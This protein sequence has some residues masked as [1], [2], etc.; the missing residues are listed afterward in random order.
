MIEDRDSATGDEW[1]PWRGILRGLW[2]GGVAA[3]LLGVAVNLLA[4]YAPLFALNFWVR[5]GMVVFAVWLLF[6]VV[7]GAAGMAGAMCTTIVIVLT[8]LVAGSQHVA[9]ALHGASIRMGNTTGWDWCS[10]PVLAGV[11]VWIIPGIAFGVW[12]WREGA[13]FGA[14]R[15]I[16]RMRVW[17]SYR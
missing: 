9:F 1:T 17:G 4:W 14:F 13:S 11:N 15:D 8:L 5:N 7:H 10:L 2:W 3:L 16:L 6:S 12:M